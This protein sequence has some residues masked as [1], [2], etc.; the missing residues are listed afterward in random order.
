MLSV[1]FIDEAQATG[2]EDSVPLHKL[3]IKYT[4]PKAYEGQP[5]QTTFE[6]WLSLL[7]GFFRIHQLDILNEV[8]DRACLEILGQALKESAQ[9]YFQERHQ[10]IQERGEVW[11][12]REAIL[13]LR[14]MYL[15][16]NP[17]HCSLQIRDIHAGQL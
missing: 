10:K 12:F 1:A 11:D 9:T 15:Y 2:Q 6:N 5:D 16:K 14:D 8:Q 3:G 4:L 13:D 7:L 17:V